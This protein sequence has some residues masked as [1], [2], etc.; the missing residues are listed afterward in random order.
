MLSGLLMCVCVR[1]TFA[2]LWNLTPER[3]CGT[4]WHRAMAWNKTAIGWLV[5]TLYYTRACFCRHH[6]ACT[7]GC[8]FGE[9]ILPSPRYVIAP[10]LPHPSFILSPLFPP[11]S[12]SPSPPLSPGI[13]T[14]IFGCLRL[15]CFGSRSYTSLDTTTLAAESVDREAAF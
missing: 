3:A 4:S 15:Y 7:E 13:S 10:P 14:V 9:E 5:Q 8:Y 12:P 6:D 1:V 2:V 11:P